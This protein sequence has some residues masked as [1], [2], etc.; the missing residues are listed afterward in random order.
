M[1]RVMH[2]PAVVCCARVSTCT[3]ALDTLGHHLCGLDIDAAAGWQLLSCI[4]I[5]FLITS[6][7]HVSSL[8]ASQVEFTL[9]PHDAGDICH[10]NH[11]SRKP[12]T[13]VAKLDIRADSGISLIRSN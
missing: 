10:D 12:V 4:C 8:S 1:S 5:A 13:L 11:V 7:S 6:C 2:L 3:G 9:F